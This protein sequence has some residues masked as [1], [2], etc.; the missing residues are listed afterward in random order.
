MM[1]SIGAKV[2]PGLSKLV[3]EAGEVVQ[4]IG[5]LMGTGGKTTHWDGKGDLKDRLE[6]EIADVMAACTFVVTVNK[7]DRDKIATRMADKLVLFHEWHK[8]AGPVID[9]ATFMFWLLVTACSVSLL[10]VIFVIAPLRGWWPFD[11]PS[12]STSEGQVQAASAEQEGDGT[13]P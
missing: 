7:L 3:E 5:K 13:D 9:A 11:S 10:V 1:F 12:A 4:V 8:A 6:E 2:W